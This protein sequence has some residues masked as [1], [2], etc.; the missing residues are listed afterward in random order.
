MTTKPPKTDM[1]ILIVEDD[2]GHATLVQENL[3]EAGVRNPIIR[4]RDGEDAWKF[5]SSPD[6]Q[7]HRQF[8]AA[9]LMLLDIRMPRMDGVKLLRKLKADPELVEEVDV[10]PADDR[11]PEVAGGDRPG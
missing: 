6:A 3:V 11:L 8:G 4:F 10:D 1:T 7:P 5:L 9:Y 2:D